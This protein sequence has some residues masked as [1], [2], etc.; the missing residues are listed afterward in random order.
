MDVSALQGS[1]RGDA[2]V[3]GKVEAVQD[4][5]A[6]VK[7][8]SGS[9]LE[10]PAP[11]G[12]EAGALVSVLP[13]ADGKLQLFP[14]RMS[15]E[16]ARV[17]QILWDRLVSLVGQDL[18]DAV[19]TSLAKQDLPGAA[20]QMEKVAASGA[21]PAPYFAEPQDVAPPPGTV[22]L[23][24]NRDADQANRFQ[25]D[26]AG[27]TWT[28]WGATSPDPVQ[29]ILARAT[30]LS[31]GVSAWV[32]AKAATP[33]A[34]TSPPLPAR[35]QAGTE[36]AKA[37]LEWVGVPA[38]DPAD[39]ASLGRK[40][41]E[42]G[43]HL[44]ESAM[45]R[46]PAAVPE[47]PSAAK[48]VAERPAA[49][50][51]LP[52]DLPAAKI[53][54]DVAVRVLAAWA[55]DLPDDPQVRMA[56]LRKAGPLPEAL[57]GLQSWIQDRP[58]AKAIVEAL[59]KIKLERWSHGGSLRPEGSDS[60]LEAE[61][62]RALA[63]EPEASPDREPLRQAAR[64]AL[65]DMLPQGYSEGEPVRGFWAQGRDGA[66]SQGKVVVRDQRNK[67]GSEAPSDFHAVEVHMDPQGLGGVDARLELRGQILTTSFEAADPA[68]ADLIR[69]NLAE[70]QERISR[71][72][73]ELGG[74]KVAARAAAKPEGA[75]PSSGGGLD[76]RA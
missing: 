29:K 26:A 3:Q 76:V 42:A 10:V 15:D 35:V 45:A 71:L 68:T 61:V 52:E 44:L 9:S 18:A 70:L 49:V 8:S 57:A 74:M 20:R 11:E 38:E 46:D 6:R 30:T 25:A 48:S 34:P 37:L 22:A 69:R 60:N 58:E 65:S 56:V 39:I 55:L 13:G 51:A 27:K 19:A 47:A 66:W 53:P 36:G 62:A 14:L 33:N 2:G 50:P 1:S 63:R 12:V 21:T 40:L 32:P 59:A 54:S 17:R 73:L 28:L 7:L 75:A 31:N 4:G 43:R 24:L 23:T 16:L 41:A 64:S 67:A 72:G 5:V